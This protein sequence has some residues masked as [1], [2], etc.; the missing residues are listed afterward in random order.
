MG[1]ALPMGG[2]LTH[3]WNVSIT[4]KYFTPVQYGVGK[5][6]GRI[7]Y[8]QVRDLGRLDHNVEDISEPA[9]VASAGCCGHAEK[10]CVR[11]ETN[12]MLAG[13]TPGAVSLI[14]DQEIG[15]R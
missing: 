11:V 14:E 7:D 1:L 9:T 5:E 3:G 4:G 8:D 2:H 15:R 6:S 12:Q 13:S 10:V